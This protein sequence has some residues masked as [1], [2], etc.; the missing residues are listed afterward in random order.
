MTDLDQHDSVP[1]IYK[2]SGFPPALTKLIGLYIR[3]GNSEREELTTKETKIIDFQ[4]IEPFIMNDRI[5]FIFNL[6]LISYKKNNIELAGYIIIKYDLF[7]R[8]MH[9]LDMEVFYV[10][11]CGCM[12]LTSRPSIYDPISHSRLQCSKCNQV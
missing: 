3:I 7:D 6:V 2:Y 12:T 8:L 1:E 9:T 5:D 11:K 10:C 4:F